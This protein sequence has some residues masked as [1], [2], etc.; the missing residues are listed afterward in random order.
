MDKDSIKHEGL[1]HVI[2][3][4]KNENNHRITVSYLNDKRNDDEWLSARK[5]GKRQQRKM[6]GLAVAEGIRICLE[7]HM[8]CVGDSKYYRQEEDQLGWNSQGL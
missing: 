3:Q 8:Y 2:P 5:P 4:R 6:I 7:N 1:Q